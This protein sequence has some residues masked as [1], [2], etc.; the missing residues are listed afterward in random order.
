MHAKFDLRS[1]KILKQYNSYLSAAW[2]HAIT[3]G[4]VPGANC[5]GT[6]EENVLIPY[7]VGGGAP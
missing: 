3:F 6:N 2:K 5:D 1:I 7:P 4:S